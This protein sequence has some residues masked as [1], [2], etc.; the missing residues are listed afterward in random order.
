[1]PRKKPGALICFCPLNNVFQSDHPVCVVIDNLGHKQLRSLLPDMPTKL[2]TWGWCWYCAASDD[3]K[4]VGILE[5]WSWQVQAAEF[6]TDKIVAKSSSLANQISVPSCWCINRD[7][8][9]YY[10]TLYYLARMSIK[11]TF[12]WLLLH[13]TKWAHPIVRIRLDLTWIIRILFFLT[14]PKII[15]CPMSCT[16]L[17]QIDWNFVFQHS[18]VR[19]FM[20][21][22]KANAHLRVCLDPLMSF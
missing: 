17:P 3:P 5:V 2:T 14:G 16:K 9:I 7:E 4:T 19:F 12:I 21:S 22:W 1:V 15:V 13:A 18:E 6:P 8:I 10:P 11:C 20:F